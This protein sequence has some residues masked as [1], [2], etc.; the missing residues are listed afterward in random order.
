MPYAN[1]FGDGLLWDRS[2]R[3]WRRQTAWLEP[4][5]AAA[6][7]DA[8]ALWLGPMVRPG[9]TWSDDVASEATVAELRTRIISSTLARGLLRLASCAHRDS[10]R[11]LA[12]TV[13][14]AIWSC[15]WR[16]RPLLG[17]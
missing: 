8:G 14:G 4:D 15:S 13:T 2:A 5:E 12:R 10:R 11:A 7:L 6:L 17:R 9:F 16:A 3:P 1:R